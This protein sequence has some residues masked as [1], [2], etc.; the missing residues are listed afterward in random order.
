MEYHVSVIGQCSIPK[1]RFY[2]CFDDM[3]TNLRVYLL[4]KAHFKIYG[5]NCEAF[6]LKKSN[7]VFFFPTNNFIIQ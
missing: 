5:K 7:V 3:W 1:E 6:S 4:L 2:P